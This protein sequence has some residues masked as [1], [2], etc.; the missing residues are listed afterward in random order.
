MISES[1]YELQFL[2]TIAC[3][4]YINV[5]YMDEMKFFFHSL[6]KVNFLIILGG[7]PRYS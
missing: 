1:I 7:L 2:Q 5:D 6:K 4:L 3:F